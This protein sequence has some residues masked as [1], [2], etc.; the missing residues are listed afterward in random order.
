[1]EISPK[2]LKRL[3]ST[4]YYF[5]ETNGGIHALKGKVVDIIL[6]ELVG[7]NED[8]IILHYK[9][10]PNEKDPEYPNIRTIPMEEII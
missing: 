6:G 7:K 2:Y 10:F 5:I 1:V 9:V 3:N 8:H 4:V